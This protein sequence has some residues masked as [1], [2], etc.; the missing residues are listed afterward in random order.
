MVLWGVHVGWDPAVYLRLA[1]RQLPDASCVGVGVCSSCVGVGV[2]SCLRMASGEG[3]RGPEVTRQGKGWG[4]CVRD[5]AVSC[6]LRDLI[7][8]LLQVILCSWNTV[9]KA[10][11]TT[12]DSWMQVTNT[13]KVSTKSVTESLSF[14]LIF[15]FSQLIC[16]ACRRCGACPQRGCG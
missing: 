10:D 1:A 14:S 15:F 11:P 12:L 4:R 5:G 16:A 2:C 8:R 13:V 7:A 6:C 9:Y 3:Q